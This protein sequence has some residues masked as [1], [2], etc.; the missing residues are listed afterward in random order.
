MNIIH[1]DQ[2]QA[3]DAIHTILNSLNALVYVSDLRTYEQLY[4]NDFGAAIW[5]VHTGKK[6]HQLQQAG[7]NSH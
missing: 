4:L 3:F 7:Q 6:C 5:G 2:N 1:N